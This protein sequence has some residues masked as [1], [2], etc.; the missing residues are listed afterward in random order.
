MVPSAGPFLK[1]VY[2]STFL[3]VPWATIAFSKSGGGAGNTLAVLT[4]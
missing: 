4:F 2:I 3:K 1:F